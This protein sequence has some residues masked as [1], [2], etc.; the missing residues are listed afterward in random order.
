MC[1]MA[2]GGG[3][4]WRDLLWELFKPALVAAIVALLVALGVTGLKLPSQ[5]VGGLGVQSRTTFSGPLNVTGGLE[6]GNNVTMT[7]GALIN[8]KGAI[9]VTDSV[10]VSG[11]LQVGNNITATGSLTVTGWAQAY[12]WVMRPRV[13]LAI[14]AGM[15]ITPGN[16]SLIWLTD[17]GGQATGTVTLS[18][19]T[20]IVDGTHVG[21]VLVVIYKDADGATMTIKD[22]ANTVLPGGTD[23]VLGLDDAAVF[24]FDGNDWYCVSY[25]N[26]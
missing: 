17:D 23:L 18:A 16:Y 19:S 2:E 14:T 13:T 15:G 12:G 8:S 10:A 6:V 21:Q 26:N 25:S 22:N 9:T 4:E 3:R 24:V 7:N 11:P 5:E 20:S 1:D